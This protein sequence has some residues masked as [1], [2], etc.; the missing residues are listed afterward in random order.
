MTGSRPI[1]IAILLLALLWCAGFCWF[2]SQIPREE[3]TDTRNADAVVVLTGG[4]LRL[5]RG[6][7]LLAQ[8]RAPRL[9]VSGV[10]NNV[11]FTSLQ[12]HNKD[13]RTYADH[14]NP[15]AIELGHKAHSTIGNAEEIAEWVEQAHVKSIRLVTGNYHMPRSV[16]ELQQAMPALLIIPDP[17]FPN[18]GFRLILLMISEYDKYMVTIVRHQFYRLLP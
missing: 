18:D 12:H 2:L 6:L 10:E 1:R 11:N 15:E 17:V 5:E 14:V 9:F 13:L 8:G 16:Y 3:T 4:S 7:A